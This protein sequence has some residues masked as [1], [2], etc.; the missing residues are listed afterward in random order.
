MRLAY[1]DCFSGVSGNM[2]LGALLACGLEEA[3]LVS[4]LRRLPLEGWELKSER[5][6][7]KGIQAVHVEVDDHGHEHHLHRGLGDILALI[8]QSGVS[9]RAK[10]TASAIFTRLGEAESTVHGVP[11]DR[12]HFHEVGAVDAIIDIVGASVGLEL[13]GIE[14]IVAS[15]LPL[16]SGWVKSAHGLL[17]VPAPATALLVRD[18]P[19]VESDVECELVTP[20]G[21]AIVTTL[22]AGYGPLPSMTVRAV[23][24]GAGTRDL[25]R[26]NVLRLFLGEE[27]VESTPTE[28]VGLETNLDDLPGEITGY[29]MD[30]LFAAGA[31]DVFF[32]PIQMK[33]NRPG[34]LVRVLCAPRDEA[35][36]TDIL[37]RETTTLGVRR[38]PFGRTVLPRE[39]RTVDTPYGPVRVKVSRWG[40]VERVEPE[41]EDCRALAEQHGVPL[42][43][44]YQSARSK[45]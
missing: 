45:R 20:T 33:K 8:E 42:V 43:A 29:L 2:L 40:D 15:P 31:L 30:R 28:I 22:A 21:A 36:C 24:Y 11:P 38:L 7:R 19:I 41:Y 13:L 12:V 14:K 10:K 1:L 3:A 44:V 26:S 18:V 32:T 5:V 16:G 4:E 17:P 6:L 34:V 25:P 27:T 9:E 23:G 35:G 37:F 39:T